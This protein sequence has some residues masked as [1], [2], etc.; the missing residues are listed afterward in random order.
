MSV[1][2]H[3]VDNTNP[4]HTH[5]YIAGIDVVTLTVLL[6]RYGVQD[7]EVVII[8]MGGHCKGGVRWF[9]F[10]HIHIITTI[11]LFRNKHTLNS[12]TLTLTHGNVPESI[13]QLVLRDLCHGDIMSLLTIVQCLQGNRD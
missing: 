4:T 10:Q 2:S 6:S 8:C 7:N 12:F 11:S 1:H 3:R 13:A 9:S 5:V